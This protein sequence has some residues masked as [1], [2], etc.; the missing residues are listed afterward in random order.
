MSCNQIPEVSKFGH[1]LIQFVI[2]LVSFFGSKLPLRIAISIEKVK[3]GAKLEKLTACAESDHEPAENMYK[4]LKFSIEFLA[5]SI[6]CKY[7][8]YSMFICFLNTYNAIRFLVSN[9]G[10]SSYSFNYESYY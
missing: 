8:I 4:D 3:K 9:L 5:L 1:F 7:S 2:P 6:F 10:T